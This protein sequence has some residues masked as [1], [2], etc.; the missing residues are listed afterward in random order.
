[1]TEP[2]VYTGR[3]CE[4]NTL[5]TPS[6]QASRVAVYAQTT[7]FDVL[8]SQQPSKLLHTSLT[9][10]SK[11]EWSYKSEPNAQRR[12]GKLLH[13]ESSYRYTSASIC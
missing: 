13:G 12:A 3:A 7:K 5:L 2:V 10:R 1:M 9:F 8:P 6:S 11:R 4:A